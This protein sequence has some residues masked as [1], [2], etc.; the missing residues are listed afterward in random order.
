MRMS[1]FCRRLEKTSHRCA[2][3]IIANA[4]VVFLAAQS[5]HAQVDL[6]NGAAN[7]SPAQAG[8]SESAEAAQQKIEPGYDVPVSARDPFLPPGSGQD[9]AQVPKEVT[10]KEF[11]DEALKLLE[12]QGVIGAEGEEGSVIV[13]GNLYRAGD[14][15][16][17]KTGGP[18]RHIVVKR[19]QANPLGAVFAYEDEESIILMDQGNTNKEMTDD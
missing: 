19:I 17:V 5:G 3:L 9:T 7:A 14:K 18:S 16:E 4:V 11:L 13:G 2:F 6:A 8:G 10:N 15:I 1:I 12:V